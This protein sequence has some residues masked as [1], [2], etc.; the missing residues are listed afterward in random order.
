MKMDVQ[1][2]YGND[3]M[4][5][6]IQ[7]LV[8]KEV[9]GI[10][11]IVAE[12]Y[13]KNYYAWTHRIYVVSELFI[14]HGMSSLE[15]IKNKNN[16]DI[17]IHSTNSIDIDNISNIT[18][19]ISKSLETELKEKMYK[20][21][22][23][24]HPTDHSAINYTCQILNYLFYFLNPERYQYLKNGPPDMNTEK[25]L[26]PPPPQPPGLFLLSLEDLTKRRYELSILALDV[27]QKLLSRYPSNSNESIWILRRMT[28]QIIWKHSSSFI[29]IPKTDDT[30]NYNHRYYDDYNNNSNATMRKLVRNDIKSVINSLNILNKTSPSEKEKTITSSF[31]SSQLGAGDDC[32]MII[33]NNISGNNIHAWTF[34]AWFI[35]N[36]TNIDDANDGCD[37][38]T[39]FTQHIRET[40][41]RRLQGV[42]TP[43]TTIT[44][45]VINDGR[46]DDAAEATNNTKTMAEHNTRMWTS[47]SSPDILLL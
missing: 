13:P 18:N 31:T 27:V 25:H 14:L 1:S 3:E 6:I 5:S 15:N 10:C 37:D 23:P 12:K 20:E 39:F 21:W 38:N 45:T 4:I 34:L 41:M 26:Q 44:K 42:A 24:A 47:S 43:T 35:V 16:T 19:I 2:S 9:N 7:D 17:H 11:S 29:T 36:I 8:M 33:K 28:C 40:I 46:A 32:E 22:L 30:P